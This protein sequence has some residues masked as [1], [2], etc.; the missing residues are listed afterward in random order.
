VKLTATDGKGGSSEQTFKVT[1]KDGRWVIDSYISGAT[2]FFDANKNGIKDPNEPST[3]TDSISPSRL[4]TKTKTEKST[5][6]K[7]I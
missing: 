5:Q 3:T 1:T 2:L 7:A 6:Q 4:S